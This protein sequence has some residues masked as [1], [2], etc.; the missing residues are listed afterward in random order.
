MGQVFEARHLTTERRM[1]VKL[2]HAGVDHDPTV[3]QRFST[4]ARAAGRAR[5]RNIVEVIDFGADGPTHWMVLEY[6]DGEALEALVERE[7]PLAPPRV[8]ALLDPLLRA[9]AHAHTMGFIHRD[10]KP[11][12]L[13]LAREE[14]TDGVVPKVLDF[15]IA[16]HTGAAA[17]LTGADTIV[18]TP[19]Y[20]APEQIES[21]R[22]VGPAAD[23]YAMGCVA[24]EML[25]GKLP[26]AGETLHG[27]LVAKVTREPEALAALRP[28]LPPA[29]CVCVMQALAREPSRRYADLDGFRR[30]LVA[31][32]TAEAGETAFEVPPPAAK[33]PAARRRGPLVAALAALGCV[34]LLTLA[35]VTSTGAPTASP[36]APAA[37]PVRLTQV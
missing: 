31:A 18:G 22:D 34:G 2:L 33:P 9:V 7:A 11:G 12:N 16:K 37:T 6:L 14:G 10:L 13:F 25:S 36:H 19:A 32:C 15:G 29:L 27:L 28:D 8:A 35:T 30:A 21:S 26:V 4:E 1:A 23:Q 3:L 5:H 20:M 17:K 24:F